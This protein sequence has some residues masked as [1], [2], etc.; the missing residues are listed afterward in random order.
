M[1][2]RPRK[3]TCNKENEPLKREEMTEFSLEKLNESHR[4]YFQVFK[5]KMYPTSI[6]IFG[7]I[8]S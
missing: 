2:D 1:T 8:K 7:K 4:N 3:I 5:S 6:K